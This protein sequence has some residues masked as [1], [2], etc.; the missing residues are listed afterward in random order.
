MVFFFFLM[1][2]RPPRSTLFPYT[3]LF[4][5]PAAANAPAQQQPAKPAPA[6]SQQPSQSSGGAF[7]LGKLQI[8]DGQIA[9]TDYQKHQSRAIYD[10]IDI[11]LKDFAPGR[12][13]SLDMTAHLPGSG[14]QTLSVSGDGGPINNADLASTPFKGT[15]KFNEVSLSSA[16]KFLNS[17]ALAG[18]DAVITGSTDLTN[19][20][21]NMAASGSLKLQDAIVHGVKVG[22]PISADFDIADNLNS[23]VIQIKKC[24]LKLG[25]TPLSVSGTVNSRPNPAVVDVNL[26]TSNAS[27]QDAA[28]LAA[29]FGVAFSSN[30]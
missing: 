17:N 7:S 1:I 5:S 12:P 18:T 16:Q 20:S 8:S 24:D 21:G 22:Y 28:R 4:R 2:R 13:F 27:I 11:T 30:A 15:V 25:S 26:N 9:V 23:D 6:P 3:T 19:A 14:S 29:A 10:H